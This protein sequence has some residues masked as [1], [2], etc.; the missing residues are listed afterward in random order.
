M[1]Q[2]LPMGMQ[3]LYQLKILCVILLPA[4]PH[5]NECRPQYLHREV[6]QGKKSSRLKDNMLLVEGEKTMGE[7][8]S[9]GLSDC[10]V[11]ILAVCVGIN[12]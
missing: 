12:S 4:S 11:A 9:T 1:T 6:K 3:S 8:N 5:E 7:K 2:F 10:L